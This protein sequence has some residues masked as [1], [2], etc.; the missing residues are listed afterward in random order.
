[1]A[2][3]TF[4][5][6]VDEQ[7][8]FGGLGVNNKPLKDDFKYINKNI[9]YRIISFIL[10]YLIAFPILYIYSRIVLVSKVKNK[11]QVK[12]EWYEERDNS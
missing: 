6:H 7:D 9:F 4:Y 8:D 11:K 12:K 10:Y 5:Y 3:K 1:M 2:R